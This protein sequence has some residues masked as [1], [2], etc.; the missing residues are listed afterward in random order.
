MSKLC[1]L[2]RYVSDDLSDKIISVAQQSDYIPG[3]VLDSKEI[4]SNN[5]SENRICDLAKI[6][7]I[8]NVWLTNLLMYIANSSNAD[9]G[10]D[11]T[12]PREITLTRYKI[13]GHYDWHHDIDWRWFPC[14]R[15]LSISIQLTDSSEYDGGDLEFKDITVSDS[16]ILRE[17]GTVIVFPSYLVHKVTPVTRGERKSLVSWIE[18]PAWR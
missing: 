12:F 15:K 8:P 6:D 10:F 2:R 3:L 14:Q 7:P 11:L 9:Y 13:G 1:I 5:Y 18:G 4:H 17:K 16:E